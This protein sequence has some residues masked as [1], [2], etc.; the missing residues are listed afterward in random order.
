MSRPRYNAIICRVKGLYTPAVTNSVL[1]GVVGPDA[2]IHDAEA[3]RRPGICPGIVLPEQIGTQR[4]AEPTV[5]SHQGRK[6][7]GGMSYAD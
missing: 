7:V 1:V 5:R 3:E 6:T 4:W 2:H